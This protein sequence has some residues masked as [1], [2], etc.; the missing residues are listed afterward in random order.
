MIVGEYD[1]LAN[2]I[3]NANVKDKI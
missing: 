3:D 2:P 1:T